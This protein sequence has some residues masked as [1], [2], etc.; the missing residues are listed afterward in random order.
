[1]YI[2]YIHYRI[3]CIHYTWMCH[4]TLPLL[5]LT[6]PPFTHSDSVHTLNP[7]QTFLTPLPLAFTQSTSFLLLPHTTPFYASSTCLH[8]LH[9]SSPPC[10]HSTILHLF[11][12]PS[13][14]PLQFSSLHTLHLLTTLP[15]ALTYCAG[16]CE[17]DS[18]YCPNE[19]IFGGEKPRGVGSLE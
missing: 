14:T 18:R 4:I 19:C 9:C 5:S 12:L 3:Y 1:M 8:I 15:L 7:I 13:H 17:P 11:H 16:S 6:P 10:T 2:Q